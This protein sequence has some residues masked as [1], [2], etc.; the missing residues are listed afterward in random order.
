MCCFSIEVTNQID[1]FVI[2]LFSVSTNVVWPKSRCRSSRRRPSREDWVR[3]MYRSF[4]SFRHV[5][6][7][8]IAIKT[9]KKMKSIWVQRISHPHLYCGNCQENT[10]T[11]ENYNYATIILLIRFVNEGSQLVYVN[12]GE[13]IRI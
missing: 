13:I 4:P 1:T 11:G 3:F 9:M 12:W 2:E 5:F 7:L 10:S 6:G 8:R